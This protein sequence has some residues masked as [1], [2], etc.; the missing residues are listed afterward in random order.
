M[1]SVGLSYILTVVLHVFKALRLEML[2]SF[3]TFHLSSLIFNYSLFR[4][5][6]FSLDYSFLE[7]HPICVTTL[8]L[9]LYIV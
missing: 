4:N 6:S 8:I 3:F 7:I 2:D 1:L 9:K 5:L